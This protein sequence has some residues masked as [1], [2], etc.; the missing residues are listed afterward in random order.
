MWNGR[1]VL[2]SEEDGIDAFP[3]NEGQPD[4]PLGSATP[5]SPL[6]GAKEPARTHLEPRNAWAAGQIPA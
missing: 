5:D 2:D 6:G 4:S 3:G 1:K